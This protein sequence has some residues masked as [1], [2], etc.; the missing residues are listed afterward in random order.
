MQFKKAVAYW[1]QPYCVEVRSARQRFREIWLALGG[2]LISLIL[3]VLATVL[4]PVLLLPL[5]LIFGEDDGGVPNQ[6]KPDG[7]GDDDAQH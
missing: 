4:V 3:I 1:W 5:T 7:K 6:F 2:L